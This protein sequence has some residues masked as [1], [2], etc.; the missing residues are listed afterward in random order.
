MDDARFEA[1]WRRHAEPGSETRP[2]P[3]CQE[4]KDA[5]GEPGR[6]YHTAAH[7]VHCLAQFDAAA[8]LMR[9]ADA[10]EMALWFHDAIYDPRAGDNEARSAELF[11]QRAAGSLEDAFVRRVVELIIVTTH[12]DP[13]DDPDA[14]FMVD[15]DLSS[16]G[17][18]WEQFRR[19][20]DA[21]REEYA[22]VDDA[23]FYSTQL[24]FL[25][26]L[27]DRSPMYCTPYFRERFEHQARENITRHMEELRSDGHA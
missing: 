20:S 15:V 3:V 7:I 5:Y 22:H 13:P 6:R 9:D 17:L 16:F 1:L 12:Q 26:S 24:R 10:V 11:R 2:G 19:D 8:P 27:L 25:R 21:V 23:R 14:G 4:L 18:P